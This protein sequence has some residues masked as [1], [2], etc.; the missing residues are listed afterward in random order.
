MKYNGIK[1]LFVGRLDRQ[2]GIDILLDIFSEI[3][4]KSILLYVAGEPVLH[5]VQCVPPKNVVM[6]G[7]IGHTDIDSYYRAA[8]VVVIPSRWEG[9]GLVALEA[10]RNGIPVIASDAGALPEIVVDG[11]TGWLYHSGDP[12]QLLGILRSISI[13]ELK[14]RGIEGRRRYMEK[15][16]SEVMNRKIVDNYERLQGV[17]P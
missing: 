10:M 5:D 1:A 13:A 9:F 14:I 15:Y 12:G 17:M 6:L 2:K 8:D 11:V 3:S 7:W 16:R 4:D